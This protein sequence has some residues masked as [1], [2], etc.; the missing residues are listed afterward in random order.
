MRQPLEQEAMG[1]E[2]RLEVA[3]AKPLSIFRGLGGS[4]ETLLNPPS[5][6]VYSLKLTSPE[7]QYLASSDVCHRGI[8]DP[9]VLA[10]DTMTTATLSQEALVFFLVFPACLSLELVVEVEWEK[11]CFRAH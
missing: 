3:K 7:S 10:R 1:A 9:R 4:K 8:N 2:E 5:L 6:R 11:P